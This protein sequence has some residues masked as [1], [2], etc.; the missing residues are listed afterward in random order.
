MMDID[1]FIV[2]FGICWDRSDIGIGI[3]IL[4]LN[5]NEF[6]RRLECDCEIL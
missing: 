6:R 1:I 4:I 5:V 2:L 3:M